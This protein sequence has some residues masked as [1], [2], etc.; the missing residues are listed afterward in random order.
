M[1]PF[2]DCTITHTTLL[3]CELLYSQVIESFIHDTLLMCELLYSQGMESFIHDTLQMCE[4]LYSQ[5]IESFI[6]DTLLN[7]S[8]ISKVSCINDSIP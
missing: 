5:G 6:H 4:L 1:I 3:M 8:H 2:L 7:N